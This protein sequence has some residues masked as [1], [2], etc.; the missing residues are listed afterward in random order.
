MEVSIGSNVPASSP[1]LQNPA[2]DLSA[3]AVPDHTSADNLSMVSLYTQE[4]V[5]FDTNQQTVS[6]DTN[7]GETEG[8]SG[9]SVSTAG[10][11]LSLAPTP[12]SPAPEPL[13]ARPP[14]SYWRP[15]QRPT[16]PLTPSTGQPH[17]E[18]E[19]PPTI[20]PGVPRPP[21]KEPAE[22]PATIAAVQEQANVP[23]LAS[24]SSHRAQTRRRERAVRAQRIPPRGHRDARLIAASTARTNARRAGERD[25]RF[26]MTDCK[27]FALGK[28]TYDP[29]RFLHDESKRPVCRHFTQWQQCMFGDDCRY[30]HIVVEP[31]EEPEAAQTLEEFFLEYS[32][33]PAVAADDHTLEEGFNYSQIPG[34]TEDDVQ[35]VITIL[36]HEES[37]GTSPASE[38][39]VQALERVKVTA[40]SVHDSEPKCPICMS[41]YVLDDGLIKMPCQH[42]FHDD[43]LT[44]WLNL[45]N[46]CPICRLELPTN[47]LEQDGQPREQAQTQ[48]STHAP[49]PPPL[50]PLDR[51]RPV[52]PAAPAPPSAHL[53]PPPLPPAQHAPRARA[54]VRQPVPIAQPVGPAPAPAPAQAPGPGGPAPAN[55]EVPDLPDHVVV[56][57]DYWGTQGWLQSAQTLLLF[58][59]VPVLAVC[60][61]YGLPWIRHTA[62]RGFLAAAGHVGSTSLV[63]RVV[64]PVKAAYKIGSQAVPPL[65][66][67][68]FIGSHNAAAMCETAVGWARTHVDNTGPVYEREGGLFGFAV[69]PLQRARDR[70]RANLALA[71]KRDW[72]GNL[73]G[74]IKTI[75]SRCFRALFGQQKCSKAQEA[76]EAR[77]QVV[78]PVAIVERPAE[79]VLRWWPQRLAVCYCVVTLAVCVANFVARNAGPP[80]PRQRLLIC[81]I[82]DEVI[83]PAIEP[84]TVPPNPRDDRSLVDTSR[85]LALGD[86]A[87]MR[88][89]MVV[90]LDDMR[91]LSYT[92]QVSTLEAFIEHP[93]ATLRAWWRRLLPSQ[94]PGR[95]LYSPT[96]DREAHN[97]QTEFG[98]GDIMRILARNDRVSLAHL[99]VVVQ[100][101]SLSEDMLWLLHWRKW[102][103]T[104]FRSGEVSLAPRFRLTESPFR[105]GH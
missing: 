79:P 1:R 50:V 103:L 35:D 71:L 104:D 52:Q 10:A 27:L 3:S 29:C 75:P 38:E 37:Q 98:G 64:Q 101:R 94:W 77:D 45:N 80:P 87:L 58:C 76:W 88:P 92:R 83:L 23:S 62:A 39:A 105:R 19:I 90:Q 36:F 16:L 32:D 25:A 81:G 69:P 26:A 68:L 43:C 99:A 6:F 30:A 12:S 46:T 28:C 100:G 91:G 82:P 41:Y 67:A 22:V 84:D 70:V 56:T 24:T 57:A 44:Q 93:I 18:P 95:M 102:S 72:R 63:R 9:N 14:M 97:R 65:K 5:S 78:P 31:E 15:V 7:Q 51:T 33:M 85:P 34:S 59:A 96:I 2:S 47:D 11:G 13:P 48:P 20:M 8:P 53:P 21:P 17:D 4:N 74:F 60:T 40:D 55:L 49:P 89:V 66:K 54:D 61:Y 73:K 42:V 86:I